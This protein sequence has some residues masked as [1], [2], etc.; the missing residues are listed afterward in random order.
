MLVPLGIGA[1]KRTAAFAPE[2]VCLNMVLEP[3]KSGISP[4]KIVRIQRPGLSQIGIRGNGPVQAI[5][6][7]PQSGAQLVVSGGRLYDVGTDKGVVGGDRIAPTAGTL[8]HHAILGDK[9]YLY[10]GT[11]LTPVAMPDDAASIV[12]IEQLNGYILILTETGR[13]YW[14]VPGETTVDALAF[15]NAESSADRGVAIRRIGDE[16]WIFGTRTI[17]A[18]QSTGDDLAPFQRA[19]GRLYERG[20][21][22]RD[23]VRRFDNSLMWVGDDNEVYRG[24]EVPT[25]VSDAG[26]A[27]R[28]RRASSSPMSAWTFGLD[29][30][31]YYVL[32]IGTEGT[33]VF[34]ALTNAWAE[35]SSGSTA[36]WL[37]YV[38]NQEGGDVS[39]GDEGGNLYRVT[40]DAATDNGT[41]FPRILTATVPLMGKTPRNNSV[42][43]GVGSSE[44]VT[45]RFRWKDGQEPFPA[46]YYDETLALAP[47]DV[48]NIYRL[49]QPDQPYRTFEVSVTEPVSVRIS[50]MFANEGWR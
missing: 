19:L 31:E 40:P 28:I 1:Y 39:A 36:G 41:A 27:E 48:V 46:D 24:G 29:G 44:D 13:F 4:D 2:V 7:R 10:D 16:F 6:Y 45:I 17:E 18:W 32:N 42:S 49:G 9:L 34:D 23:T 25:V 8:F 21:K 22:Y 5:D 50:G 43:I 37:A 3:D 11:T 12:D 35:F 14:I 15:A 47:L 33:F 26:L 20:C 38:G 30:H